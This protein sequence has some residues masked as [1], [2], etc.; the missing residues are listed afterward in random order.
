M[1]RDFDGSSDGLDLNNTGA[2]WDISD[3]DWCYVFWLEPD[4]MGSTTASIHE[5]TGTAASSEVKIEIHDTLLQVTFDAGGALSPITASDAVTTRPSGWAWYVIGRTGNDLR[6]YENGTQL[7]STTDS[8]NWSSFTVSGS[9]PTI[10]YDLAGTGQFYDG[11]I[12]EFHKFDG[13]FPDA[14]ARNEI[15]AK[16]LPYSLRPDKC[17]GWIP[18]IRND[19]EE[20]EDI[21]FRATGGTVSEHPDIYY[22]I[23]QMM[24]P[25]DGFVY[26]K[27]NS[28]R[29]RHQ[30]S[31]G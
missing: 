1:A 30:L 28:F 24:H 6:I 12:A 13:W 14:D 8:S 31:L 4:G 5:M 19:K 23:P 29:Q 21:V 16:F 17:V 22:P 3:S 10:G 15:G 2:V 18:L 27:I 26:R 7:A 11:D 20:I 9:Y 25:W